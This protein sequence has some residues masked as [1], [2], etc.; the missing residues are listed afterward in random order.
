MTT[1]SKLLLPRLVLLASLLFG[2][3]VEA[4]ERHFTFAYESAVLPAGSRELELWS[5][6]RVKRDD[7]YSRFDLRAEFEVGLTD[8][9]QTSLYLNA[10]HILEP[11]AGSLVNEFAFDGVSSEWKYKLL[12][13]VAD[14]LGLALYAE[15]TGAPD[16]FEIEAK[17]I[18]DKRL[19][20]VLLAANVVFEQEWEFDVASVGSETVLEVDLAATYFF[21]DA[22]SCGLEVRNHNLF[23]GSNGFESSS[24]FAGPVLAYSTKN[25]W[26]ALSVLPQLPALKTTSTNSLLV[27]DEHEKV[28]ARLLFSFHL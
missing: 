9:L 16:A 14:A 5:T 19:G 23:T 15:L 2:A 20:D 26:V 28:N 6:W 17:V 18:L 7:Y 13:P 3:S 22:F 27:L 24:L 4:N 8:N 25:F 10:K 1:T 21:T 11:V 12:D